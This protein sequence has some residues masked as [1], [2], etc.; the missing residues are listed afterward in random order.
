MG[1]DENQSVPGLTGPDADLATIDAAQARYNAEN[2]MLVDQTPAST[3]AAPVK[4]VV[5][6]GIVMGPTVCLYILILH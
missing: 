2:S 5:I 6:D 3:V 1:I 4:M